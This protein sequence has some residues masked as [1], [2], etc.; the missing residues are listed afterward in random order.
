MDPSDFAT[1]DEWYDFIR[2]TIDSLLAVPSPIRINVDQYVGVD[3][4]HVS[5]DIVCVEAV[6]KPLWLNLAVA[7]WGH[8][9]SYPSY[10][11][12]P[13]RWYHAMR[14][15]IT[16]P[17][18]TPIELSVGD[19]LHYDWAYYIDDIFAQDDGVLIGD[20]W[21]MTTI[22]FVQDTSLVVEVDSL[23][24]PVDTLTVGANVY[25]AFGARLP[26]VASVTPGETPDGLYL[27][28]GV[29]NPFSTQTTVSFG[30]ERAGNVKLSVYSVAGRL[31]TDLVD[32]ILQPGPY[33]ASWD[34]R[35]RLGRE[36]GSGMYYYKLETASGARTGKIVLLK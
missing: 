27:G 1:L 17:V 7:E 22:I 15:F 14:D 30:V 33:R 32:G 8:F 4:V 2:Q 25:Q 6:P 5:F 19:S 21:D 28:L 35:D 10:P 24:A 36:V 9:Y 31:V 13:K 11:T 3:S 16:D 18:G 26:D 29:P 12:T 23:G 20:Q 34:G